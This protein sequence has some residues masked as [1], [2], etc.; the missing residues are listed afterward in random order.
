VR[1]LEWL[2]DVVGVEYTRSP[3]DACDYYQRSHHLQSEAGIDHN[4]LQAITLADPIPQ[5]S[6]SKARQ[7]VD[8]P[9]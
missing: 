6:G 9:S 8:S 4:L 7:R 2:M 5:N 1:D 3:V